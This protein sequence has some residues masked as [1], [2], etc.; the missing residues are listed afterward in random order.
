MKRISLAAG[1]VAIVVAGTTFSRPGNFKTGDTWRYAYA[2]TTTIIPC[3]NSSLCYYSDSVSGVVS[4]TIDSAANKGDSTFWYVAKRDSLRKKTRT[5]SGDT[6]CSAD[7]IG[8]QKLIIINNRILGNYY[9]FFSFD[10]NSSTV[11]P[12]SASVNG[13][14]VP[15]FLQQ[16]T[17]SS[18]NIGTGGDSR[19]TTSNSW[20]WID[21]C[22][23]YKKTF[24]SSSYSTGVSPSSNAISESYTLTQHNGRNISLNG[25]VVAALSRI[26]KHPSTGRGVPAPAG[27]F[28][29]EGRA[30]A[31]SR[32]LHGYHG[33]VVRRLPGGTC[34]VNAVVR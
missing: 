11:Y 1:I 9:D 20:L 13:Q 7:S 19:S 14:T 27:L 28:T 29:P 34:G 10:Q 33:I 15:V 2:K 17:S 23:L 18:S 21:S 8:Y 5:T 30:L 16:W 12:G 25:L 6:V 32:P 31:G 24:S 3:G 4:F 26:P 22:G